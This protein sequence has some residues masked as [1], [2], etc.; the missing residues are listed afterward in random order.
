MKISLLTCTFNPRKD[1]FQRVVD[2]ISSQDHEINEWE[3]IVV[4]N[5][6]TDFPIIDF[7]KIFNFKKIHEPKIG[8]IHALQT[9]ILACTGEMLIIVDDDNVLTADYTKKAWEVYQQM[10]FLGVWGG[11]IFPEYEVAPPKELLPWVHLLT[12]QEFDRVSWS[13]MHTG[14]GVAG[15]GMCLRKCVAE[16]FLQ[17]IASDPVFFSLGRTG[18]T[19]PGV[20]DWEMA[21]SACDIGLGL[22]KIPSLKLTHLIPHRRI[23]KGYLLSLQENAAYAY[24]SYVSHRKELQSLKHHKVGRLNRIVQFFDRLRMGVLDR[25][26]HDAFIRGVNRA[27]HE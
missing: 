9:G 14:L 10:P 20:D 25:E 24:Q 16:K 5:A 11:Q 26:F 22:G 6:S 12:L 7:S 4:D 3:Y 2:A 13:N 15:A 18:P 21:L 17:N 8:K 1:Y 23:D 27:M 19:I